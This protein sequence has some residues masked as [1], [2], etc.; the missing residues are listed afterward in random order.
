MYWN[1]IRFQFFSGFKV[2]TIK[3][4]SIMNN[5]IDQ[6]AA[7]HSKEKNLATI[8]YA[9]QAGSFLIGVTYFAGIIVNYMKMDEVR[10]TWVESHFKWQI[11]KFWFSILWAVIGVV[12]MVF[13]IGHV[14][15][16][17]DVLWMVYRIVYGWIKLSD[18]QPVYTLP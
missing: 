8:V 14:V 10:G 17:I 15:L 16:L 11:R 6:P 13:M 18:G 3:Q 2:K 5:N 7:N 1:L 9:L 4:G 12:T